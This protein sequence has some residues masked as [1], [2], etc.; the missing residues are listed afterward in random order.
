MEDVAPTKLMSGILQKTTYSYYHASEASVSS[1]KRRLAD[2]SPTSPF[3]GAWPPVRRNFVV[4]CFG[5]NLLS[6]CHERYKIVASKR[7][8]SEILIYASGS[9]TNPTR[10]KIKEMKTTGRVRMIPGASSTPYELF[11]Q[12]LWLGGMFVFGF[13]MVLTAIAALSF[14]R[15]PANP[16]NLQ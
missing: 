12:S 8:K 11:C 15:Q 1:S 9:A 5:A 10:R 4:A 14:S 6:L 16:Q 3:F 7:N 2:H 13:G